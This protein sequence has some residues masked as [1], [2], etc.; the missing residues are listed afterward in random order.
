MKIFRWEKAL[1]SSDFRVTLKATP[2]R[3]GSNLGDLIGMLKHDGPAI[4]DETLCRP[5]DVSA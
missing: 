1:V 4:P 3:T 2:K 5:V